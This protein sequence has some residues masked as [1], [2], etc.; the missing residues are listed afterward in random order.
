MGQFTIGND[1]AL[2][3][4]MTENKPSDENSPSESAPISGSAEIITQAISCAIMAAIAILAT[5]FFG[6]KAGKAVPII[7]LVLIIPVAC[8]IDI[9]KELDRSQ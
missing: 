1:H 7:L 4:L 6:E 3:K 8:W 2:K 5:W 9:K